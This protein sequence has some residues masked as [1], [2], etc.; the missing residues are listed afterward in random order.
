MWHVWETGEVHKGLWKGDLGEIDHLE[1][2]G[3][4]G[5]ITLKWICNKWVGEARIE[6]ICGE[7]F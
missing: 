5:K 2:L 3:V 7:F 6:L 4:N 1:D